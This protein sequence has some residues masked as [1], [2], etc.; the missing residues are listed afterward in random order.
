MGERKAQSGGLQEKHA[1][2]ACR[3]A[4]DRGIGVPKEQIFLLV[5]QVT[6]VGEAHNVVSMSSPSCKGPNLQIGRSQIDFGIAIRSGDKCLGSGQKL[7]T[8]S[9]DG[10]VAYEFT[11]QM[12]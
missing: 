6:D 3:R 11:H 8:T 9:P 7:Q 12:L 2:C 5:D 4:C 1:F 10:K